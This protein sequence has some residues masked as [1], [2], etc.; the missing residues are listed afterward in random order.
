M[1]RRRLRWRWDGVGS[2]LGELGCRGKRGLLGVIGAVSTAGSA[3]FVPVPTFPRDARTGIGLGFLHIRHVLFQYDW[4]DSLQVKLESPF[5]F[6]VLIE[7]LI[8]CIEPLLS[9]I[10][11]TPCSQPSF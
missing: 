7:E 9:V 10:I 4:V 11:L 2:F 5:S 6:R 3:V 8:K 1:M